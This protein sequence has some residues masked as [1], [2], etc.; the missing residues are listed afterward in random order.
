MNIS[1]SF[2][3]NCIFNTGG[4]PEIPGE[5][6]ASPGGLSRKDCATFPGF[7]HALCFTFRTDNNG[8]P[9]DFNVSTPDDI[10]PP[11]DIVHVGLISDHLEI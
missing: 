8:P 1:V 3:W 9:G 7:E 11:K 2:L 5:L 4:Y 6:P 10:R